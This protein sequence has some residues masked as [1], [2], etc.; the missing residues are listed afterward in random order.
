[1]AGGKGK[2]NWIPK[3]ILM[4]KRR[5][6]LYRDPEA[7]ELYKERERQRLVYSKLNLNITEILQTMNFMKIGSF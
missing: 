4:A 6:R 1:M 5:A 2:E 3:K 7:H